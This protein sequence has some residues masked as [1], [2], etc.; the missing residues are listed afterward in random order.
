MSTN[1]FIAAEVDELKP[2]ACIGYVSKIVDAKT[3]EK[4]VYDMQ[5]IEVEPTEA[6]K[7]ARVNFLY[8]PRW[9]DGGFDPST[10][11]GEEDGDKLFAVYRMHIAAKQ[12]LSTLAGLSGSDENFGRLQEA[13]LSAEGKDDPE[14]VKQI[15]TDFFNECGTEVGYVLKQ[16]RRKTDETDDNGRPVYVLENGYEIGEWFYP[17]EEAKLRLKKRANAGKLVLG[18]EV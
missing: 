8:Q 11:R 16:R 4:G 18:F 1:G 2:L 13:L 3:T 5:V 14:T 12:S 15:L 7:K 17:S 10:L 6:G 9:L